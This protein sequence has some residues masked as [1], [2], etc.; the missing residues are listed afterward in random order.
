M[1]FT[2]TPTEHT[3]TQNTH[4]HIEHTL[5]QARTGRM[6]PIEIESALAH[7][8]KVLQISKAQK[9]EKN[10]EQLFELPTSRYPRK[11]IK[12]VDMQDKRFL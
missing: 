12:S 6:G 7:S 11:H 10:T 5:C 8:P 1:D 2:H 4:T 9:A 3:H